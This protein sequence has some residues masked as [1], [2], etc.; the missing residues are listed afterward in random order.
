MGSTD[1]VSLSPD[2]SG[3]SASTLLGNPNFMLLWA[4]YGVS[5]MG[6]HLSEMAILK[7][8]GALGAGAAA[9]A[10]DARM[11]FLLFVPFF[12]FGPIM[13]WL[14]D[15]IPRRALM[16][17]ADLVRCV[18]MAFFLYLSTRM[19]QWGDWGPLMPL[20]LVGVFAALFSPAR[21]AL[22]PTLIRRDQLVR[23]NGM[24]G[25]LGIIAT[26][27]AVYA[28]GI[29]VA[30]YDVR[31]SFQLDAVTFL[32]SAAL[33]VVLVAPK[34]PT[35]TRA[36]PG[37]RVALGDLADGFRYVLCHRRVMEL[38]AVATLIWLCGPLVKCVIPA[39]VRDVYYGEDSYQ[40]VGAY[41][42]YLGVGL[43]LG[44]IIISV[45]GEALR[46][47]IA[48]TWGLFGIGASIAVF[49]ASVFLPLGQGGLRI[50]GAIGVV[51][52]GMFGLAVM[53]SF[54]ALLQRM[55][56]DR[57]RGRVFGVKNLCC[58]GALLFAT[59]W[60]GVPQWDHLDQ[61]VGYILAAVAIVTFVAG[62]VTLSVRLRRGSLGRGYT[63]AHNLNEF[64]A[65]FWWRMK[66]I[67]P[68][69][70]PREGPIIIAA[71]HRCSAD[72]LFLHAAAPYRLISFMVA[73]EYTSSVVVRFFLNLVD[74]IP[75]KRDGRDMAPTKQAM[76]HLRDGKALG[77][78]IEGGIVQPG[79]PGMPR[80]GV[81]MI[82]LKTGVKVIP[83]HISGVRYF[84]SV[85]RGLL[86]RHRVR[87]RFGPP[88]DLS[89]FDPKSG[90]RDATR[91]ATAKIYAAIKA[92]APDHDPEW[93]TTG[94]PPTP[95]HDHDPDPRGDRYP[96]RD[97]D[98][99]R[100]REG[101]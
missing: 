29:L 34:L 24:M 58:T 42:A 87:I 99:R 15:R 79:E 9:T 73:A 95:H 57:Y 85:V 61:W 22:L 31:F 17:L 8:Q 1:S 19:P 33:L 40:Y 82:A 3:R 7:T 54:N 60:L 10:I 51:G 80:D 23:A 69:T 75:V 44:A 49:A 78:F 71:N 28:G 65:R 46:S 101:A 41:R 11:T 26:M 37:V 48:I 16:I 4:A 93:N 77:I 92:L 88:V 30:R 62:F 12:L 89:E 38:L 45:L 91:A 56:P 2:R 14:A 66:R 70:M 27:L 21:E 63:F 39:I 6:D 25:G 43:I 53:A 100:N 32:A 67:G 55:V 81:A 86:H 76:R 59:G 72:P 68:S 98:P 96:K 74:C 90:G 97:P 83:V 18:V 94:T 13:G 5:A 52:A 20:V 36:S 50:I 35:R 47:E 64:I 84:D